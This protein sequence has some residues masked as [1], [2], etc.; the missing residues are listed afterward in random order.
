VGIVRIFGFNRRHDDEERPAAA[1]EPEEPPR[2]HDRAA[3]ARAQLLNEISGFLLAN[4][5]EVSADN[6]FLAHQAFSG[7]NGALAEQIAARQIARQRID[8][9][10]LG[11]TARALGLV[12][13]RKA[14]V[15]KVMRKL[16]D[17][18]DGFLAT[19][20]NAST[21][22]SDFGATMLDH[23]RE[24]ERLET[25][26]HE[27]LDA[28][29]LAELTR[30]IIER[31]REL[32]TDMLRAEDEAK[33]LRDRLKRAQRDAQIDYLTGLPNRR[34]FD[35]LYERECREARDLGE[36]LSVALCDIDRFKRI[37]DTHGHAVGDRVIQTIAKHFKSLADDRCH[38][39]RHGGEEFV[40]LFR[41]LGIEAAADMLDEARAA[42]ARKRL[43]NRDT[44]EPIGQVSF[45]G[46]VTSVFAHETP[47]E[48]LKAADR[49]LYAAKASGRNCIRTI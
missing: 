44:D 27:A 43:I 40:M 33:S 8:G 25:L 16:E 35:T 47:F 11:E 17:V 20:H 12:R 39:A 49:A 31:T 41:G 38:V 9:I 15:D 21:A 6:L 19:S 3:S 24:A 23:A 5:L 29:R 42:F 48:A 7:A 14:E 1:S 13:D 26:E 46:G 37:N 18:L 22:A 28:G 32:E 4:D 45:S 34:A 2:L 36:A 10:W 30:S